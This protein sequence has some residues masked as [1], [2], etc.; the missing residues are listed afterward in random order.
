MSAIHGVN[1][2]TPTLDLNFS[3]NKSL[4]DTVTGRNLVTFTRASTGTYVGADGLI[5]TAVVDEPRFDHNPT[6]GESLGLL[7]EEARTNLVT[8]SEQFEVGWANSGRATLTPNTIT[9]PDGTISADSCI[10]TVTGFNGS[11]SQPVSLTS[12]ITYA[13][14]FY[15][16]YKGF[17][18]VRVGFSIQNSTFASFDLQSGS[19][20]YTG[21][22]ITASIFSLA[23][24][25]Y[26]CTVRYVAPSTGTYSV[27]FFPVDFVDR[28]YTT[29]SGTNGVYVWGAQLEAGSFPTSYIPTVAST[30]TRSADVASIGGT[31][32]SSWYRQDEGTILADARIGSDLSLT[33]VCFVSDATVLNHVA[34]A[35]NT[36]GTSL[37][38]SVV[39][40]NV[41]QAA[42]SL[43]APLSNTNV[44]IVGGYQ[45]NN[46]AASINGSSAVID[47]S[48][49]I[50]VFSQLDIGQRLGTRHWN[51][52]IAR[53]SYY[54]SRL[55]DFQLQQLTK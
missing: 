48:G 27:Q 20:A 43:G 47:S 4:I 21:A 35:T 34:F 2:G 8:Y 15:L 37:A 24:D 29:V 30:V 46:L 52:T 10:V 38:F 39:T 13:L 42:I 49:S 28:T 50:P 54:P 11:V 18:Y 51:S 40:A 45:A 19:I 26:R 41:T 5:K 6:T 9:S 16:K 55:Q 33:N 12:G 36:A 22:S 44:R 25:W 32:F 3:K 1:Y 31:N 53:L 17:Q 23:N 14:S 7:V